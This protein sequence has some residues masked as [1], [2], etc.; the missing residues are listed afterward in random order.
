MFGILRG[1][2]L[3]VSNEIVDHLSYL[4]EAFQLVIGSGIRGKNAPPLLKYRSSSFMTTF[5]CKLA[6]L[7]RTW[8]QICMNTSSTR[9]VLRSVSSQRNL[10]SVQLFPRALTQLQCKIC[11]SLHER[12]LTLHSRDSSNLTRYSTSSECV[13]SSVSLKTVRM[14]STIEANTFLFNA[15][16]A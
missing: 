6:W 12:Q 9:R 10:S 7:G 16:Q 11:T 5:T 2:L 15:S 13:V 3:Q 4:F 14:S 1:L 8:Y